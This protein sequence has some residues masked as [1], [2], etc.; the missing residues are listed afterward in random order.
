M[1]RIL[2]TA[3]TLLIHALCRCSLPLSQ[4]HAPDVYTRVNLWKSI[5]QYEVL[6]NQSDLLFG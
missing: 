2:P 1:I 3:L 4:S 6:A 5:I